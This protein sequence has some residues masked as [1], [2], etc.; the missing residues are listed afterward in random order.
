MDAED[1]ILNDR[2]NIGCPQ[3]MVEDDTYFHAS[4][5]MRTMFTWTGEMAKPSPE[6]FGGQNESRGRCAY[7]RVAESNDA[8]SFSPPY[9]DRECTFQKG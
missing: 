7:C 6:W 5:R 1:A 4:I 2:G 3:S 8:D 9:V